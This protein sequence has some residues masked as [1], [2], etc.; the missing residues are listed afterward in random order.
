MI[1][2]V[3]SE[4]QFRLGT[5]EKA[6]KNYKDGITT[7]EEYQTWVKLICVQESDGFMDNTKNF[8]NDFPVSE[9]VDG[10]GSIL[11]R[12]IVGLRVKGDG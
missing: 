9:Y 11:Y 6:R 2:A 10:N 3:I 12:D 8:D 1:K 7:Y 4:M 5:L